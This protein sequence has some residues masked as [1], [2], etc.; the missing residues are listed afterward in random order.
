MPGGGVFGAHPKILDMFAEIGGLR[1]EAGL[2]GDKRPTRYSKTPEQALAEIG[3]LRD[4]PE[5]RQ[6][7]QAGDSEATRQWQDLHRQAYPED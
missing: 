5:F 4:D 1:A 3:K 6:K 2:L 7:F